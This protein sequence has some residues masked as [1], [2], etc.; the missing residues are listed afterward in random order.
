MDDAAEG[1]CAGIGAA[2]EFQ[3]GDGVGP[4]DGPNGVAAH[5]YG[6]G[7]GHEGVGFPGRSAVVEG[8]CAVGGGVEGQGLG[9]G[10]VEGHGEDD[11]GAASG[12]GDVG[13]LFGVARHGR[14]ARQGAGLGLV[15]R[16]NIVRD[17]REGPGRKEKGERR[18]EKC[19][20]C[21]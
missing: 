14:R 16:Q 10:G 11:V 12:H 13:I 7:E 18:E 9:V 21:G 2:T 19:G 1:E 15:A 5:G 3:G 17:G 20:G 6:W 4:H 8:N